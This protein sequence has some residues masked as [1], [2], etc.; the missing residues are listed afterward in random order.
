VKVVS[1][2]C[3]RHASVLSTTTSY[4]SPVMN[5]IVLAANRARECVSVAPVATTHLDV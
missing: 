1:P 3:D 5:D 4:F 2:A